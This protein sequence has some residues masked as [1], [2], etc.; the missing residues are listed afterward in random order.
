[1]STKDRILEAAIDL[2]A[3]QG[4]AAVSIRD[5][6]RAVGIKESSLYNH[7]R[8]KEDLFETILE[9]FRRQFE[10]LLPPV[11]RL[12]ALLAQ[13]EPGQFLRT[14]FLRYKAQLSS[15]VVIKLWQFIGMEQYRDRRARELFLH[16]VMHDQLRFLEN[17]FA[18]L[19]ASGRIKPLDP[20][21]LAA[22]YGYPLFAMLTEHKLLLLDG[23]ETAELE[24]RMEEHIRFFLE[25]VRL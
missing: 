10:A 4:Y 9:T 7:F 18:R 16:Y 24:R 11:E 13:M 22:E 14:G 5:I 20:K 21:L 8:N 17:V 1:M 25:T 6:T 23:K 19:T 3:Q 2:F 15:P 12:D